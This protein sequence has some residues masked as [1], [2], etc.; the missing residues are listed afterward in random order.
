MT[1]TALSSRCK[2]RRRRLWLEPSPCEM[3]TRPP[4][5]GPLAGWPNF[6]LSIERRCCA[7]SAGATARSTRRVRAR[8]AEIRS[9]PKPGANPSPTGKAITNFRFPTL[10]WKKRGPV[11]KREQ[12]VPLKVECF[13]LSPESQ[14]KPGQ[15]EGNAIPAI[16]GCGYPFQ[17]L[18]H[19]S[20]LT[21]TE[22]PWVKKGDSQNGL[23]WKM[24]TW[25]KKPVVEF[26]VPQFSP[27]SAARQISRPCSGRWASDPGV[28]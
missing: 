24:E 9:P 17:F 16:N 15:L 19:G 20:G 3:G 14:S 6:D 11:G 10:Q 4:P 26:L 7:R 12:P 13:G 1:F 23:P 18:K 8:E 28:A 25:T 21:I 5:P 2:D 22:S 27:L